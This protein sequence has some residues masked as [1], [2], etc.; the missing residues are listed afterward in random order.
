MK[1]E[2]KRS[3]EITYRVVRPVGRV[4]TAARARVD[5][6]RTVSIQ[7][8]GTVTAICVGKSAPALR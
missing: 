1:Q 2:V 6:E 5:A 7:P 4:C 3:I 8:V